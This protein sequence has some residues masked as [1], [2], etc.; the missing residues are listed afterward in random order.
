MHTKEIN[1]ELDHNDSER[2]N[3]L[4]FLKY[5]AKRFLLF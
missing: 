5:L 4:G 2:S 3:V 1:S